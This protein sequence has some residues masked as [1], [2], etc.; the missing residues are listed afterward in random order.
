MLAFVP[1]VLMGLVTGARTSACSELDVDNLSPTAFV[2]VNL[3]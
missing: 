2:V 3:A 1:L